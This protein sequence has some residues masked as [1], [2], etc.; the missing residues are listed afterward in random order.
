MPNA[1]RT[2]EVLL[3]PYERFDRLLAS[4]SGRFGPRLVDLSSAKPQGGP[5]HEVRCILQRVATERSGRSL[6]STAT[7]GRTAT[8]RA[9][10]DRLGQ[11][12][13]LPFHFRD[14]VMTAGAMPALNVV[15]RALFGPDDEVIVLTPC[16]Q[17]YSLYLHNLGIPV[18]WVPLGPDKHLDLDAIRRAI[19]PSTRGLLLSQPCCPTGVLYRQKELAGLAALLREAEDRFGTR[20]LVVS[21]EVHRQFV[22]GLGAFHSPLFEY[23]RSLSVYSFGKALSLQSQRIG[24]VAV[25]PRMPENEQVRTAIERCTRVMGYGTPTTLMQYAVTDLLEFAPPLGAL[26]MQQAYVR[27]A[28]IEY[29]YDVCEA[30]ATFHVYVKCPIADDFV[31]A[32]HL[33]A[34]GVL[35]VPSTLFHDPGYVRVSLTAR[36]D[37]IAAGLPAFRRVLNEF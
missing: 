1:L 5:S 3:E 29:G 23:D 28:L 37:A 19:G 15:F 27:S 22:W 17:D 21:D 11:D 16:W 2:L 10:A 18:S 25:S 35:V 33:A 20:I 36:P 32:E 6:Q 9:I 7:G 24:Y 14:V 30:D 4:A 13:R 8:R 31:F 26:A 12:Y 34:H